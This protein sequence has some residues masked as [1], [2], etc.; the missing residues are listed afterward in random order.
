[1]R[2]VFALLEFK[3]KFKGNKEHLFLVLH[4]K[5]N[6]KGEEREFLY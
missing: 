6:Q 4:F 2:I 1:M 5:S 3:N